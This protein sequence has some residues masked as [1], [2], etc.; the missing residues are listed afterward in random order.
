[1]TYNVGDPGPGLGQVQKYGRF[2][3]FNRILTHALAKSMENLPVFS[4][5]A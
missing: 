5:N 1:M 3:P 2:K 4:I